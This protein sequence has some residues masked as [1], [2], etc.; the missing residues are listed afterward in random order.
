MPHI[1][2]GFKLLG[3]KHCVR[4]LHAYLQTGSNLFA[5]RKCQH[6]N[7]LLI[8]QHI[9]LYEMQFALKDEKKDPY[10]NVV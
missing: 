9:K 1:L 10:K 6:T 8:L 2:P 7:R 3:V 4:C 5:D